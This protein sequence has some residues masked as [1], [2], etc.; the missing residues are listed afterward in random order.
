[1]ADYQLTI[2]KIRAF[3]SAADQT[4]TPQLVELA[5]EYA[6]LC[7]EVNGQLRKC[8]DYLRRGLRRGDSSC[9]RASRAAGNGFGMDLTGQPEWASLCA[10]YELTPPPPL[11][12]E[13]AQELNEAY[14]AAQPLEVMLNRH[15]R[16][17]LESHRSPAHRR[18]AGP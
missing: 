12:V 16:L 6:T 14:A 2:D 13:A 8:T 4:K 10:M 15:R 1:M 11:L 17:A 9:R 18:H 5:T 7:N 3:V